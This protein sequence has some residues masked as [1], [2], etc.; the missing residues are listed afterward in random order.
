ME[1]YQYW[2]ESKIVL[3]VWSAPNYSYRC[4]NDAT[5]VKFDENMKREIVKFEKSNHEGRVNDVKHIVPYFL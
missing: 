3:T 4:N 2:F 5:V 1:G